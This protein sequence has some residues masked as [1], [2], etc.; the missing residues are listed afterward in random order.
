MHVVTDTY[1]HYVF[2]VKRASGAFDFKP[3]VV[4]EGSSSNSKERLQQF[5]FIGSQTG[6][7]YASPDFRSF[8]CLDDVGIPYILQE[9]LMEEPS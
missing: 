7:L 8:A 3:V 1:H 5:D 6:R 9:I 4:K 2:A